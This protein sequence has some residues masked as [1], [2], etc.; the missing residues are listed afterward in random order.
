[1][2]EARGWLAR[3]DLLRGK[4]A[5]AA[6][7]YL[8]ELASET[9]NIRRERLVQSLQMIQPKLEELDEDFDAPAHALFIA[10]RITNSIYLDGLQAPLIDRLEQHS[11]LFGQGAQSDALAIALMRAAT[12][13]GAPASTLR[14]ADRIPRNAELRKTGEYNWLV[15][16]A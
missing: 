4:H 1:A 15:G 9:S 2:S 3:V 12:R 16:I 6:K 13:M 7:F 14:Y 8:D 5:A 11:S 10:N